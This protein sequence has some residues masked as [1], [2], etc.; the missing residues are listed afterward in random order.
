MRRRHEGTKARRHEVFAV[1]VITLFSVNVQ[2]TE[3]RFVEVLPDPQ[4][5]ARI[6]AAV[7]EG[8]EYLA[9]HQKADGSWPTSIH[10]GNG[11]NN[12]VNAVCVL[13]F[14]GRGH[15]PNRGPYKQVVSN[16]VKYILS[17][18]N[19]EGLFYSTARS[20]GVMY[21]HGLATLAMIEAYGFI[22]SIEMRK[23][24]QKAVD[25]IV[26]AQNQQGGWRYSARP[27]DADLSVTVMQVVP[28]RAA[29][30][31]RLNVPEKTIKNAAKYVKMCAFK[32]G[33]FG[34]QPHNHPSMAQ[35][36]A[37]ALSM[38]LLGEYDDPSVDKALKYL[39]KHQFNKRATSHFYY[40][41]YYSMQAHFQKGGAAWANWYP[42]VK[43]VLL[44]TQEEDGSWPAFH[45]HE[46]MANDKNAHCFTTAMAAMSLE[47][48]MHYLPAYQK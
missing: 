34:Y 2:A 45:S 40:T 39:Q 42:Q 47:V 3:E 36:A 14:L 23:K 24:V 41:T 25:V 20:H 9:K 31:A 30:N 22:P 12:G 6:E 28:L 15:A 11:S 27:H 46:R 13:A 4:E 5:M 1:I 19:N 35:S 32:S 17:T 21:E 44:E 29:L 43:K 7:D 16:A 26:K 48:F 33:G 8:L 18:Q 10:G 37:G 38:Q